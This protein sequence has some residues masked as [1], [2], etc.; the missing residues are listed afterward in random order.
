[1]RPSTLGFAT[2]PAARPVPTARPRVWAQLWRDIPTLVAAAAFLG[3][4]LMAVAAPVL[5]PYPYDR[6]NLEGALHGPDRTHWLGTD[7]Y[8]RDVFSRVAYGARISLAVG[9]VAVTAEATIGA[10]WGTIAGLYGGRLDAWMMRVVDLLIAFPALLLAIL[11][12]GIFGRSLVNVV[13]ALVLTAWPGIARLVRSQVVVLRER[14]FVEAARAGGAT[15]SRVVRRH[16]LPNV[17]HLVIARATLDASVIIL[18][19]ATLSFVGLG[20]Q[21]PQ[22]SWGLMINEAF[23]Y[24][25]STPYL[26]VAPAVFLSLTVISLNI[27]GESLTVALDPRRRR[28]RLARGAAT[29]S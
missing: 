26:L 9:A 11:I 7:N 2:D 14:E 22:P 5:T 13:I 28:S 16:L 29:P 18:L 15:S 4:V 25:R 12:T 8:G 27:L 23:G 19:E 24:L 20:V 3:I 1:M 6:Q 17:V 21:P 10:L